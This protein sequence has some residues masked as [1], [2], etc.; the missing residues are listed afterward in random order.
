MPQD[1]MLLEIK[2]AICSLEKD[3]FNLASN[4]KNVDCYFN[5]TANMPSELTAVQNNN[6]LNVTSTKTNAKAASSDLKNLVQHAVNNSL[7]KHK[8]N[9]Y[10]KASVAIYGLYERGHD[11]QDI[12][13]LLYW[14]ESNVQV[15][16][17]VRIGRYE[18]KNRVLKVELQSIAD[19]ANLL[20]M[21]KYLNDNQGT[22]MIPITKWL[23]HDE[24]IKHQQQQRCCGL[25]N[26]AAPSKNGRKQYFIRGE[27][28]MTASHNGA[29]QIVKTG[30]CNVKNLNI[31]QLVKKDDLHII[32][33]ANDG[34]AKYL[35]TV[36]LAK[37]DGL[38]II[39]VAGDGTCL[40]R[41]VSV[42]TK[43]NKNK[44]LALRADTVKYMHANATYYNNITSYDSDENLPFDKYL[45]KI[46]T[47]QQMVGQY[48]LRAIA[49]VV[50]KPLRIYYCQFAPRVYYPVSILSTI[51][52][53]SQL[54]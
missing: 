51:L 27:H 49:N 28:I 41:A 22:K 3:V 20:Q 1:S 45:D 8:S 7:L 50:S 31:A 10:I 38:H 33:L 24:I 32:N 16:S 52:I 12:E 25:N 37:K 19:R 47:P 44:H 21:S 39:D 40:F 6:N 2:T 13:N 5:L 11:Y 9:E 26:S 43:G 54:K 48:V 42:C 14:L 15:V 46:E 35:K 23:S 4:F 36:E 18:N 30:N 53:A 34:N 17:V 29:L